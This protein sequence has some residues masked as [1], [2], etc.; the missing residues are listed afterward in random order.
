MQTLYLFGV[1]DSLFFI[2]ANTVMQS[3]GLFFIYNTA[4]YF[5]ANPWFAITVGLFLLSQGLFPFV[6]V[7]KYEV[8]INIQDVHF[9]EWISDKASGK[10]GFFLFVLANFPIVIMGY[11][12]SIIPYIVGGSLIIFIDKR[13]KHEC[14]QH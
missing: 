3:I 9:G 6:L 11:Q 1:W 4:R 7:D 2:L 13:I 8:A 5:D 14:L 12:G 10:N